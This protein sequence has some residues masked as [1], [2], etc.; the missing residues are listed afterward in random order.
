MSVKSPDDKV[1]GLLINY[2]NEKKGRDADS[3]IEIFENDESGNIDKGM[4]QKSASPPSEQQQVAVDLSTEIFDNVKVRGIQKCR[5][6][7]SK[8][9]RLYDSN[10][11]GGWI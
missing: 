7:R 5:Y 9:K 11:S 6:K 2:G 1:G 8:R 4:Y 3:P 10:R